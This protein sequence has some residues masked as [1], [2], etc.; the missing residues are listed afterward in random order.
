MVN[1]LHRGLQT[2]FNA[3]I[4]SKDI[5]ATGWTQLSNFQKSGNSE[6]F[7]ASNNFDAS[8]GEYTAPA[9]GYYFFGAN[10]LL[11]SVNSGSGQYI[12]AVFA[13]DGNRDLHRG[14]HANTHGPSTDGH[15]LHL[16]NLLY[17]T[18]GQ[19]VSLW[20]YSH[21]DNAY[22]VGGSTS[23]YGYFVAHAA[24]NVRG[25]AVETDDNDDL[26]LAGAARGLLDIVVPTTLF[27]ER[28][29]LAKR[30]TDG[31]WEW[32][33]HYMVGTPS[34]LKRGGSGSFFVC[35]NYVG[36]W[37]YATGKTLQATG[38]DGF[39][40]KLDSTGTPLW[41]LAISSPNSTTQN[42][43]CAVASNGETYLIGTFTGT[44][45]LGSIT[46]NSSNA[47]GT[48]RYLARVKADGSGFDW[49]KQFGTT[50]SL[51]GVATD[52]TGR[53]Y[54]V[55]NFDK[56]LMLDSTTLT[57]TKQ[58]LFVMAFE[59]NGNI[60]WT[61]QTKL[62]ANSV[63]ASG[64]ALYNDQ[65]Y[66]AADFNGR[67]E[68][69]QMALSTSGNVDLAL[70]SLHHSGRWLWVRS[71]SGGLDDVFPLVT[72]ASDG[73]LY[74]SAAFKSAT[75]TFGLLTSSKK[76]TNTAIFDSVITKNLP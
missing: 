59:T 23:F 7:D 1:L 65:I 48:F 57:S 49:A 58:E 46:L 5:A 63:R 22:N 72:F 39:I 43:K 50:V 16:G 20:F 62:I 26:F 29:F 38:T 69:D 70:V 10:L 71:A 41:A 13:V 11:N 55:G 73:N 40:T 45:K 30:K 37:T 33:K 32:R 44:L 75:L 54:I 21:A 18:S 28:V 68:F 51:A 60:R 36:N 53:P 67:V 25:I 19:K 64:I 15:S 4:N 17:L 35:G 34:D 8:T 2:G 52:S 6:R 56:T 42:P 24:T 66:I 74:L 76:N 31:V 9:N 61:N 12:R 3:A 14:T 47:A 27:V